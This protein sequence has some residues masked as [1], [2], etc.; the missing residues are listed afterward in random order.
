MAIVSLDF[1]ASNNQLK[2]EWCV[3]VGLFDECAT[4]ARVSTSPQARNGNLDDQSN[5]LK[6]LVENAGLRVRESFQEVGPASGNLNRPGLLKA[7]EFCR[8]HNCPLIVETID[9][10]LR[11]VGYQPRQSGIQQLSKSELNALTKLCR[12]VLV[13]VVESQDE[14]SRGKQTRRGMAAKRKTGGRPKTA[15][16]SRIFELCEQGQTLRAIAKRVGRS[17]PY[18]QR[19]LNDAGYDT[20]SEARTK[21]WLAANSSALLPKG[22]KPLEEITTQLEEVNEVSSTNQELAVPVQEVFVGIKL[23]EDNEREGDD[24]RCPSPRGWLGT[25]LERVHALLSLYCQV[26]LLFRGPRLGDD[27]HACCGAA[28]R[29]VRFSRSMQALARVTTHLRL[30]RDGPNDDQEVKKCLNTLKLFT[31]KRMYG[32]I[33][34]MSHISVKIPTDDGRSRTTSIDHKRRHRCRCTAS[35][36]CGA[37]AWHASD[38]RCRKAGCR[39][40]NGSSLDT[41]NRPGC[42]QSLSDELWARAVGSRARAIEVPGG[43]HRAGRSSAKTELQSCGWFAE[44]I[45]AD[46]VGDMSSGEVAA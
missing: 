31:L 18:I 28:A 22:S 32:R 7:L 4:S 27:F 11:P 33:G 23:S 34:G 37:L 25:D 46:G 29:P 44:A 43:T 8:V 41:A 21:R 39:P 1:L 38:R 13:V 35:L 6:H 5:G 26:S 20:S 30:S 15:D 9:R 42:C 45:R 36:D 19:V 12:G 2:P 10:L 14:K 16:H 40:E 17:A 3:Q 24:V